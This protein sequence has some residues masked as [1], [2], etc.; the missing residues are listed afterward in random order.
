[1]KKTSDCAR[2]QYSMFKPIPT[3]TERKV[4]ELNTDMAWYVTNIEE[5]YAKSHNVLGN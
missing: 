3:T 5:E 4:D 2:A 1:M